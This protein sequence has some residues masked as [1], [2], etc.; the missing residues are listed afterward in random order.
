MCRIRR[1]MQINHGGPQS[2]TSGS[3]LLPG[4][5]FE[6]FLLRRFSFPVRTIVDALRHV[7]KNRRF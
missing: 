4:K 2:A 3:C 5:K 1:L 6:Y 7:S